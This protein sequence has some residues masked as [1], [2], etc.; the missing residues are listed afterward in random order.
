[1]AEYLIESIALIS[2]LIEEYPRT[3]TLLIKHLVAI[4]QHLSKA[5]K[6]RKLSSYRTESRLKGVRVNEAFP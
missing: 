5:R 6:R 2:N 4:W 1:M 3:L